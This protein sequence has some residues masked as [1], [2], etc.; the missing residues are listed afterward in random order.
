METDDLLPVL[1]EL[2]E[3]ARVNLSATGWQKYTVYRDSLVAGGC[4][5]DSME[6]IL[7]GFIWGEI[8]QEE[9]E[10]PRAD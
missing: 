4:D 6:M 5:P 7:R 8:E 9:C 2:D 3:A 10:A 1:K